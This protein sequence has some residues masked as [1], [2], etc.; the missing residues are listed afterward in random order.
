MHELGVLCEVVRIVGQTAGK[1]G[2]RKIRFVTLA[3][4]EE[5]GYLPVFL[6]KLFPV[7]IEQVP[8]MQNAQLRIEKAEGRGIQVKS[9]E[10]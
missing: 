4:G 9:I 2:I 3:V 8:C 7:A 6:E 5:S 1:N 10:Y